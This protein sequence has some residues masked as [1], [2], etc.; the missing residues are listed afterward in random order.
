MSEKKPIVLLTGFLGAG[1]T[2]LVRRLLA[3]PAGGPCFAVIMSEAS[4]APQGVERSLLVTRSGESIGAFFELPNGC[5]CCSVRAELPAAVRALLSDGPP[6][7]CVLVECNGLADATEE[8]RA[9]WS[10]DLGDAELASLVCLVDC[11]RF[12]RLLAA[13]PLFARQLCAAD[14]VVL[15]KQAA[16]SSEALAR[17]EEQVAALT[18]AERF[19]TDF[20]DVPLE[21][22][23]QRRFGMAGLARP[24][25]E[26][27][28]GHSGA[29]DVQS[30]FF[31]FTADTCFDPQRLE[32]GVGRLVWEE[33]P[34]QIYRLKGVFRGRG[35]RLFELQGYDEVFEVTE[36]QVECREEPSKFLFIAKQV[37]RECF[38]ELLQAALRPN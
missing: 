24:L 22:L 10:A 38:A 34:G 11:S 29:P 5:L 28:M 21:L 33:R 23:L 32:E 18:S 37:T 8:L 26:P 14:L 20:A 2:T 7:D 4:D 12:D 35:P 3:A 16:L 15:N 17:L 27:P 9:L 36:T 19:A 6:V 30:H 1:K 25:P 31:T 13:E